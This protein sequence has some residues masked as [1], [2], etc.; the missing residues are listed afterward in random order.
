MGEQAKITMMLCSG[1][2][3][4]EQEK[5]E[6]QDGAISGMFARAGRAVRICQGRGT[7]DQRTL[8]FY[9]SA[10]IVGSIRA[11]DFLCASD[12]AAVTAIVLSGS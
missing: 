11:A 7:D 1:L 8:D 5:V 2:E 3:P 12:Q 10:G 4:A 9:D 6:R